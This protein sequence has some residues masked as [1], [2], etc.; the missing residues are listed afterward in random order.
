[1][2]WMEYFIRFWERVAVEAW[3]GAFELLSRL[4]FFQGLKLFAPGIIFAII[5]YWLH[6]WDII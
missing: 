1:M 2:D 4:T 6:R 5:Y 3:K